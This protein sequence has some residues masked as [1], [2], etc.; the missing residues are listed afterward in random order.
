MAQKTI[1]LVVL[2]PV[3]DILFYIKNSWIST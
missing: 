2:E 1:Y 3:C